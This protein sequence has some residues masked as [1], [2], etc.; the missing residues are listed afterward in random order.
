[1]L[2]AAALG[3]GWPREVTGNVYQWCQELGTEGHTAAPV[4][5]AGGNCPP[6]I[7]EVR[8]GEMSQGQ[9]R[10]ERA[11]EPEVPQP[12]RA[13]IRAVPTWSLVDSH[14]IT[15]PSENAGLLLST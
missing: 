11:A 13:Y 9:G 14:P 8:E 3:H 10:G 5:W 15:C 12:G 1:M 4:T 2:C 6:R 7:Q